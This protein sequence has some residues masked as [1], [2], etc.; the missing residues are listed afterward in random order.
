MSNVS[1]PDWISKD[2]IKEI[3][4][5]QLDNNTMGEAIEAFTKLSNS[6]NRSYTLYET[7]EILIEIK[8]EYTKG[9]S[10]EK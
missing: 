10:K 7:V 1:I 2:S 3:A 4:L 5:L 6:L 9:S 8:E